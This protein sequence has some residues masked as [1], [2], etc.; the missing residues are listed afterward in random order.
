[1]DILRLA[2]EADAIIAEAPIYYN[3]MAAQMMTV[4][5]RLCCT[6]ACKTYQVGPKKRVGMFLTC[7]G[8]EPGE[9]KRHVRK[10]L[11]LPSVNRA[12]SEYRTEVFTQCVSDSTCHDRPDYLERAREIARWATE[13]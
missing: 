7:T 9:M 10:I 11:P 12:T 3:C 6:F 1:M 4:I 13:A 8:S 2:H 5:N